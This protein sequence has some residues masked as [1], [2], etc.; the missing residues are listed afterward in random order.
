MVALPA[1]QPDRPR[2]ATERLG[3]GDLDRAV[4][5]LRS[6]AT[7]AI[8]TETVYGLAADA[9]NAA[10]V[11][12][13]FEAKGRPTDHPLIVHIAGADDLES[14]SHTLDPR[15]RALADAHWPG[16]L[17][18]VVPRSERVAVA[19]VG[20]RSS[21][22]IR[23]PDHELTLELLRRFGGGLA[24]PSANRFGHV[25]PT[26]ADHV[27]ADLD[28]RI[29]AVVD[30]GPCTVGVESTI[31]ELVGGPPTLLRP[32]GLSVADIEATLGEVV[33]D[34][35]TTESRA[36]GM[37]A[38]HYAP[39]ASVRIVDTSDAIGEARVLAPNTIVIGPEALGV[40]PQRHIQLASD[41]ASFAR[42]LYRALRDADAAGAAEIVI[43]PPTTGALVDA[44]LDRL[45]K[46]AAPRP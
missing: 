10:A 7:V 40:P 33:L 23:V 26:T 1:D 42:H 4:E 34:G 3:P 35:R 9:S 41:A 32:G 29:D 38:S 30:G 19:T 13:I 45:A 17:T 11:G 12:R 27:L 6:G 15:A 24:A 5:L 28:G 46:A 25:S 44:V 36:A 31:I 18:L 8:P 20:G 43:V 39:K 22:G 14:W 37:L 21:V 16:P 2:A